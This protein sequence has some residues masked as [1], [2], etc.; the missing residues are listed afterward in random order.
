MIVAQTETVLLKRF[1]GS[2]DA[3]AFAEII[4][5]HAGLVYGA[6]L[7]ILADVDRASD[8]AQETFL[9][10]T[11]DAGHVT[12]SLPGWLH[13]VA[14]HKAIDCMRRDAS[15]RHRE[16]EYV[17]Q[18]PPSGESVEWKEISP[19]V[20]VGLREL[21]PELREVL[22]LHFLEGQTTREIA[23]RKGASQATVSRRIGA[24]VEQLR[25]KLRRRGILIAVGALSVLLGDN[26][27]QAAPLP[28]LTELGKMAMV[29]GAASAGAAGAGFGL[30]AVASGVVAAVKTKAVA[31]AAVAVI[32]AGSAATYYELTKPSSEPVV[33]APAGLVAASPAP[34]VS[35]LPMDSRR[36]PE[37]PRN[38]PQAETPTE[39]L[40]A[41]R[42]VAKV[43]LGEAPADPPLVI[44]P[45]SAAT[46][47][48]PKSESADESA[49]R[50]RREAAAGRPSAPADSG[51]P[52]LAPPGPVVARAELKLVPPFRG[53]PG[54]FLGLQ[55]QD[56]TTVK[57]A[58]MRETPPDAPREPVYFVVRAGNREIQGTTYRSMRPAA[59]V[60]LFLDTDG[61]GL[62]SDEKG[63][64]GRLLWPPT[65][66]ATYEFGP[67]F[68]RQGRTEPGGD[69]FYA[70]CSDG[71]WLTF[72]PAFYRDGKVVLEGKTH[73]ITLVDSDF[74]GRF[75]ESF[76][77]PAVDRYNPG[78]DVLAIDRNGDSEFF[79]RQPSD[80]PEIMPLCRLIDID[81][82][83]YQI[84]VAEDGST[85]EFR[86]AD[87]Q[88]GVLDLGGKTVELELWS[89]AGRQRLH[90]SGGTW[91]LPAGRYGVVSL[92]LIEIDAGNHWEF[93]MFR[94]EAGQLKDFEIKP[95][96]T[97]TFKIGP[98]FQIRG[99]MERPPR[100][101]GVT[102]GFE[103]RGQA[104]ELYSGVPKRN[105]Q[106]TPA[107]SFKI[108]NGAGQMVQSGRF[109]YS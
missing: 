65:L 28:L 69:A 102:V 27:V 57:P 41:A 19:Y 71:R 105:G 37:L 75:N 53:S 82:R 107:P 12:G 78:C 22:I 74:D 26:G 68:L 39:Q 76:V 59:P 21:D 31:V 103:L 23:L 62:W 88:F 36:R 7:R 1:T 63:Y 60:L 15:R 13:R 61:D 94:A 66:Y 83:Y 16:K 24:G 84:E 6:A 101:P 97:T 89:D 91:R 79:T 70:Q 73:R 17:A 40:I 9:Q 99:S 30:H 29:G 77:P 50:L 38:L 106:E 51:P 2:G 8:V 87:P 55:R 67:V 86:R 96:Q 34:V 93:E 11:K 42:S 45:P 25:A 100:N 109:A 10:L 20:D 95:G 54:G 33:A 85:V 56:T 47:S 32:G 14:T 46:E 35:D 64:V 81:G 48:V 58:G 3:E 5:R 90:A 92:K 44:D 72:W 108:L 104:G 52:A 98:P 80:L 18:Q 49:V 4:R 43:L